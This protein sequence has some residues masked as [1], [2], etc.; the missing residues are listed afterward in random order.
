MLN[1]L[2]ELIDEINNSIKIISGEYN[3]YQDDMDTGLSYAAIVRARVE[4]KDLY[5]GAIEKLEHLI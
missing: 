1:N 3:D 4:I 2:E 5:N